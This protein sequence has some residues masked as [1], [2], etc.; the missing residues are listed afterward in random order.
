MIAIIIILILLNVYLYRRRERTNEAFEWLISAIV[1]DKLKV[2]RN[3]NE[4]SIEI[5]E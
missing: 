1:S 2:T 5:K 3:G 4:I